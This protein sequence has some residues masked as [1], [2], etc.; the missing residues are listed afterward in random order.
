MKMSTSAA[1]LA[2]T[3]A[4]LAG[5]A[6]ALVIATQGYGNDVAVTTAA[7]TLSADYGLN[8]T[9]NGTSRA[10]LD[11]TREAGD[12][13]VLDFNGIVDNFTG[14]NLGTLRFDLV[15]ASF[16]TEGTV[17]ALFAPGFTSEFAATHFL[18]RFENPGE[19]V[20][21]EFGDVGFGG[22]NFAISLAGLAVGDRFSL[23]LSAV[24]AVPEP[25]LL[26]L[27]GFGV[28][29]VLAARTRRRAA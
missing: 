11:V 8:R 29:G 1:V 5:P 16:V 3:L 13:D 12:G 20:G 7:D 26:A 9:V 6:N 22:D 14:F 23:W 19:P 10:R 2:A 18:V 27:F 17:A 4:T 21:A 28:V 25:A 24:D 15:G